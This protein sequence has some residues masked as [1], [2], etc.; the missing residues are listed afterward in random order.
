[1]LQSI[2]DRATG[3][4]AWF[5][6]AL[7]TV[8]FA[9]W[10]IDSYV[11][12]PTNPEVA[13][14]GDSDITRV[15]LQ[16][17]YDQSYQ[18]LQQLMGENFKPDAIDTTQLRRGVLD[19]LVQET[20]L[21][22][23]AVDAGYRVSDVQIMQSLRSQ[24]AFQVD[25]SFS[26]Q[27][28][29]EV[30]SRSGYSPAAYEQQL[31]QA[32]AVEQLQGG[33]ASSAFVTAL[34][35]DAALKL[36][37]QSRQVSYVLLPYK[38]YLSK[39]E[40]TQAD[41][42]NRYEL[43]AADYRTEE[44]VKLSYIELE[45][46]SLKAADKPEAEVLRAIYDAEVKS[47]FTQAERRRASHILVRID[48]EVDEAAA[49]AK[50]EALAERIKQGEDFA[51][52][53]EA[54]SDDLGS[55]SNGGSLDWVGRGVMVPEFEDAL[56]QMEEGV[57]SA[58]VLTSFGWHLILVQEI[59]QENVKSFDDSDVQTQLLALYRERELGERFEQLAKQ[60]DE[61]SFDFPE[62]LEPVAEAAGLPIKTTDWMSRTTAKGI[63]E[64]PAVMEAAFS[65]AVL[66]NK[67]NSAPLKLA[68]D[69]L[70]VIRIAE[71]EAAKQR[72]IEEV[73]VDIRQALKEE[74]AR[75]RSQEDAQAI[76][77]KLGQGDDLA[78]SASALGFNAKSA[79][80]LLRESEKP[81]A[82]LVQ[83]AFRLPRPAANETEYAQ[84]SL[85][86]G[87]AVVVV[88]AV[89]DGDP[90]SATEAE[91]ETLARNLLAAQAQIEFRAYLEATKSDI[92]VEIHEDQL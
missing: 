88:K 85:Q 44:R 51:V 27:R 70:V 33:L 17:A 71:Y 9:F 49:K 48:D 5:I 38:Q 56:Y 81:D 55:R 41:V 35:I 3:P 10:G 40:V 57:V 37:K 87:Q 16:R 73:S 80:W 29:R 18:R 30:L 84:L 23:H 34:D 58:P 67:E 86:D 65:N 6:V 74:F 26:P 32:L 91:R 11:S 14:V 2:R 61:L 13:E 50:A 1:M 54:E 12:A 83:R 79:G 15:Q 47:R 19:N 68:A 82:A 64:Q 8:P 92:S 52:V 89:R 21:T 66:D 75:K 43:D 59:E 63:G 46:S 22:Q 28:Y 7:I 77:Q 39:A 53:A 20:L 90:A 69:R 62:S 36:Q 31:R 42:E 45:K 76:V 24:P 25:G 72:P 60:L 78:S 4:I